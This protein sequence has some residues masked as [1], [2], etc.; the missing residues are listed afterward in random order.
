MHRLLCCLR[1]CLLRTSL[2]SAARLSLIP[3]A[4]LTAVRQLR[5]PLC[6]PKLRNEFLS[7]CATCPGVCAAR[8]AAGVHLHCAC[9]PCWHGFFSFSSRI[10]SI[11][12]SMRALFPYRTWTDSILSA[13]SANFYLR[14][15]YQPIVGWC[16]D[17]LPWAAAVGVG[18]N[19][20]QNL[21]RR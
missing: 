7:S 19:P 10:A 15:L 9:S 20:G 17:G 6:S 13:F 21:Q 16:N 14:R 4:A 11:C 8:C 2:E 18:N 3:S 1:C 5:S 12:F